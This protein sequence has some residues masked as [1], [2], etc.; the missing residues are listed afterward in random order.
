MSYRERVDHAIQSIGSQLGTPLSL[1]A[2][3]TLSLAFDGSRSC[4]VALSETDERVVLLAAIAEVHADA[5]APLFEAA[6]RLNFD[7]TRTDGGIVGYH[8]DRRELVVFTTIVGEIDADRLAGIL[9]GFL[10]STLALRRTLD[11]TLQSYR[12]QTASMP[13]ADDRLDSSLLKV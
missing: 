4:R 12:P 3:G 13:P 5:R 11:E 6:L 7:R 2:D 10:R 8:A 9:N 1:A